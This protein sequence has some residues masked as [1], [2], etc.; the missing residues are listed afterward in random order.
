MAAMSKNEQPP[1]AFGLFNIL[2]CFDKYATYL[3][4]KQIRLKYYISN[5]LKFQYETCPYTG[6]QAYFYIINVYNRFI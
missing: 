1:L 3:F 2:D 4:T 6:G 5:I